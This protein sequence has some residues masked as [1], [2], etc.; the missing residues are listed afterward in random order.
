VSKSLYRAVD[1]LHKNRVY[2][3]N[4]KLNNILKKDEYTYKLTDL[5]LS[6]GVNEQN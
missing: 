4:I 1:S 5:V 6:A 2:H 3:S